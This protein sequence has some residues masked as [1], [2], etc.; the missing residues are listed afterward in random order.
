MNYAEATAQRTLELGLRRL[1]QSPDT[2]VHRLDREPAESLLKTVFQF[3]ECVPCAATRQAILAQQK[4]G[5]IVL[6]HSL[7]PPAYRN[8][9]GTGGTG[10]ALEVG[11]AIEE[12]HRFR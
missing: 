11:S 5:L 2:R 12:D 4:A 8:L 9:G 3:V 6:A 1:R 7:L 10:G